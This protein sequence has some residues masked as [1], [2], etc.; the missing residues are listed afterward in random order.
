M[1]EV[2]IVFDCATGEQYDVVLTVEA[3]AA[4]Q[5]LRAAGQQ[6]EAHIERVRRLSE[7]L[8]AMEEAEVMASSPDPTLLARLH[9]AQRA[10]SLQQMPPLA[11][12]ALL[13]ADEDTAI[14]P[15]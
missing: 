4:L 3:E 14:G 9:V 12:L 5:R 2:E 1:T 11:L 8:S 7:R 13:G 6:H 15:L 10:L